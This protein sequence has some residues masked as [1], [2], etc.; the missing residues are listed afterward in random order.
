M[1]ICSLLPSATEIVFALGLGDHLVAVTHEC[2]LPAGTERIPIITQSTMDGGARG[3]REIHNHVTAAAHSGSSL[4]S[5]DQEL[6]ERLDP[7]IILTQELCEV[8][9]VSYDQVAS[10]VHRLGVRLPGK[11]TILSLQPRTL[12]EILETIRQV[13]D[14][15]GAGE[16]AATLVRALEQRINRVAAVARAAAARPRVFDMEW[17]A[18][19]YTAGHWVPEMISL[20]GG[21]DEL[22]RKG[23]PSVEV[24]W[25]D[26]A[27][28]D[29][30]VLILM[31][32]SFSLER[33][34]E[35]LGRARF[36]DEWSRLGAVRAGRVYV[37]EGAT[38]FSRSGPRTVDGLEILAEIVH[39][40]LFPR[41][42]PPQA[43][44]QLPAV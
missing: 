16:R 36:P 1:R 32:C 41:T 21:R 20:A 34:L 27:R 19:P 2:D 22:S 39:P 14:A 15:T 18:P 33:T 7:D 25:A 42:S 40:E 29:P 28:Y 43:W 24:S 8:C 35:E 6:L 12:G 3:S 17:L 10:A 9:A 4:Y 38:Y 31:P 23:A 37:V 11:R 26:I 44:R 5:L 13:G 30:E